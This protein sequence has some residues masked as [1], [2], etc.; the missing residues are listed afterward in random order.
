MQQSNDH[1]GARPSNLWPLLLLALSAVIGVTSLAA[2]TV[3]LFTG[4]WE[5]VRLFEDTS[6]VLVFDAILSLAFFV[7]HSGM[8]RRSFKTWFL[9]MAPEYYHGAV[10][11]I[12]AGVALYCVVVLWQG[13]DQMLVAVNEP[14][15]FGMRV[16]FFAA[17]GGTIWAVLALHAFEPFGLEAIRNHLRG[18]QGSASSFTVRGP[19]RWVRHPQYF[20]ILVM[21]WCF[22]D[23]TADRLL[24]NVLWTAWIVVG[25]VWEERDLTV[26]FGLQYREYQSRVPMFIPYRAPR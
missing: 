20:F 13:S 8:V 10:Y 26:T 9:G 11:S 5:I 1:D 24:F 3:F 16:L 21:I 19:Y 12:A 2:F 23:L 17:I 4:P 25:A 6:A 18:K 15:R 14:W 7:Q 22:P